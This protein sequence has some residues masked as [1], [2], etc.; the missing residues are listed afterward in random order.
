MTEVEL[1]TKHFLG[2]FPESCEIHAIF[3]KDD[4][5]RGTAPALSDSWTLI[6]PRTKLGPDRQHY[7]ELDN[8][9]NRTYTHVKVTIHPDGGLKRIRVIGRKVETVESGLSVPSSTVVAVDMA[10]S[11]I[12]PVVPL[13]SEEFAPFGQVIQAYADPKALQNTTKVTSANGGT[14]DKYHKLSLLT[15]SYPEGTGATTGIS[16]YRC[17]PLEEISNGLTTLKAL[18]RHP[19]TSQAF[20]PLGRGRKEGKMDET[21]DSYLVVVALNGQ[22]DRPD[23][24]S[25][26]AFVAST[27][28]GISYNAGIWRKHLHWPSAANLSNAQNRSANDSSWK[29]E[30]PSHDVRATI[31]DIAIEPGSCLCRNTDRR[32]KS[33]GL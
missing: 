13:T 23:M 31:N 14:A 12:I 22:D 17:R 15:S 16:V 26:K 27:A 3:S 21:A 29:G 19:Y 24:K 2:N 10:R 25:L 1:D 9:K 32:W 20:I 18:E 33:T 6:L 4:F 11:T 28:Q 7:F 8:V 5:D 30:S